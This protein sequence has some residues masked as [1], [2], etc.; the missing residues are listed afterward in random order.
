MADFI[1][2]QEKSVDKLTA[3]DFAVIFSIFTSIRL[4]EED[5]V[6]SFNDI[7]ITDQTKL[8]LK[9]SQEH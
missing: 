9:K 8:M 1:I 5:K 6:Y 4:P 7:N 3:Q 2:R